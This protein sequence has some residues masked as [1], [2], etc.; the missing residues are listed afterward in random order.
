MVAFALVLIMEGMI[1]ALFPEAVRRMMVMVATL[2]TDKFRTFGA[3][4]ALLGLTLLMI[5]Q[6]L[7]NAL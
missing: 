3:V 4:M 1:Y 6:S 2:P 7:F 5:L